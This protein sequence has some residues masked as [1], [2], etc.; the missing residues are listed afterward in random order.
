[1]AFKRLQ[2]YM[3]INAYEKS[4]SIKLLEYPCKAFKCP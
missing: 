3:Y 1:M 2:D 4:G